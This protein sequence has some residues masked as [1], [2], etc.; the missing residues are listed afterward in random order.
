MRET[1]C[2]PACPRFLP[3]L[4]RRGSPGLRR[5]W[6]HT[7]ACKDTSAAWGN[8][9]CMRHWELW[10]TTPSP[11]QRCMTAAAEDRGKVF[12]R[13]RW[14]WTQLGDL[15]GKRCQSHESKMTLVS[16]TKTWSPTTTK[17]NAHTPS[18]P[19]FAWRFL[20]FNCYLLQFPKSCPCPLSW[21]IR[22]KLL[23]RQP[24]GGHILFWRLQLFPDR[25][26]QAG[27]WPQRP[28]RTGAVQVNTFTSALHLV[29]VQSLSP[30]SVSARLALQLLW[31][32]NLISA[33][34]AIQKQ[35]K[36]L[37]TNTSQ[38]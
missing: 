8:F 16:L 4:W 28:D 26:W 20:L 32:T 3:S 1:I 22:L 10:C 15:K 25:W 5:T 35:F 21:E 38:F 14:E 18:W 37:A 24:W 11:G 34:V 27:P 36:G 29:F 7:R 31:K 17:C 33:S 6:A 12:T 23:A 30:P 2:P 19:P 13:C 9:L